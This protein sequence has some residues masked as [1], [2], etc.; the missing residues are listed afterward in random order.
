MLVDAVQEG[1]IRGGK[2]GKRSEYGDG[3]VYQ[4]K[5]PGEVKAP[6]HRNWYVTW[7]DKN[8]KKQRATKGKDGQPFY[9]KKQADD[10][11]KQMVADAVKGIAPTNGNGLYY[12]DLREMVLKYHRQN[13]SKS[14]RTLANDEDTI[15]G[16][17]ELDVYGGVRN[18]NADGTYT[19]LLEG[20]GRK[21]ST[22]TKDDWYKNFIVRRYN[23][24]VSN[25]TINHS[26]KLFRKGLE[27][28]KMADLVPEVTLQP[29]SRPR[30]DC[31][32]VEDF[33]RLIGEDATDAQKALGVSFKASESAFID[34]VFHPLVKFLFY[35]GV[36]VTETLGITWNQIKFK[37][38]YGEY[39][40]HWT[41]NKTESAEPKVLNPAVYTMLQKMKGDAKPHDFVFGAARSEGSDVANRFSIAF[42]NAM[43]KMKP[44]SGRG[45][46]EGPAGN[47]WSCAVCQTIDR[48]LPEPDDTGTAHACTNKESKVCQDHRVP[49]TW[50]YV[51]PS[52]HSLR[53][54]CAVYYLDEVGMHESKV[55]KI[56]GHKDFEV[57]RGYAR[58]KYKDIATEMG[59]GKR[60][61]SIAA[62]MGGGD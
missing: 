13:S 29:E 12:A 48:T 47:A 61:K 54:S 6:A 17:T 4:P 1:I 49:M 62:E 57:F 38:G 23:E 25:A 52:V 58:H 27:L 28:A 44:I 10:Y 51:G 43:L 41:S 33:L 55:T 56:T 36:R 9:T 16:L 7:Q 39:W 3:N 35:Q 34:K 19:P 53:A 31:L 32:Y 59:G 37:N 60:N 15:C 42:H 22:I 8:G 18:K 46:N 50:A 14:L 20:K 24:G 21:V 30:E 2:R 5:H 26:G 40:P 45:R 11:R